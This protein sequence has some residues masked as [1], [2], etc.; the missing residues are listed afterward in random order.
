ML[1]IR[2]MVAAAL[3]A[4]A[5]VVSTASATGTLIAD[6]V[7]S[8]GNI[9]GETRVVDPLASSPRRKSLDTRPASSAGAR[10]LAVIPIQFGAADPG[11]TEAQLDSVVF[12][13]T[14]SVDTYYRQTTYGRMWLTGTVVPTI[15]ITADT[16]ACNFEAYSTAA[17]AA[18]QARGDAVTGDGTDGYQHYMFVFPTISAC[19]WAGLAS[20]PGSDSWINGYLSRRVMAHELGHNLGLGHANTLQCQDGVGAPVVISS[21]CTETAYGDPYETM[22]GFGRQLSGVSRQLIGVLEPGQ[23]KVVTTNTT[24]TLESASVSGTGIKSLEIPRPGTSDVWFVEVR[25]AAGYDMFGAGDTVGSG[26]LIRKRT[27]D[28]WRMTSTQLIDAT[29]STASVNDAAFLPGATFA[30]PAGDLRITVVSRAANS[31]SVKVAFGPDPV[32]V[33][34]TGI[35]VT[36]DPSAARSWTSKVTL[37]RRGDGRLFVGVRRA[38][39]LGPTCTFRIRAAFLNS[40]TCTRLLSVK[41]WRATKVVRAGSQVTINMLVP[42][43]RNPVSITVKTP[44]LA[45]RY[46]IYRLK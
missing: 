35:S 33:T 15:S 43:H 23:Q 21:T 44:K 14:D 20:V 4:F 7:D 29:P 9:V 18:L 24:V 3:T 25:S 19:A 41:G 27:E 40:G 12:S 2:A 42:G 28:P 32:T 11:F 30:D 5:A 6:R 39:T 36:S 17:L 37:Y 13:G 34:S 22:G 26:I 1:R 16:T 31:A 45:G 46:R 38:T 8:R 10:N